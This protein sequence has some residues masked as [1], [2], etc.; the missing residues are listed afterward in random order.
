MFVLLV[1]LFVCLL[2]LSVGSVHHLF[3]L[4]QIY[5]KG[6]G[7]EIKVLTTVSSLFVSNSEKD[8]GDSKTKQKQI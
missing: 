4:Q 1:Y 6:E 3:N 5:K 7:E 8:I 2:T